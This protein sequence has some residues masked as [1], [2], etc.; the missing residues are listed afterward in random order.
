MKPPAQNPGTTHHARAR[1]HGAPRKIFHARLSIPVTPGALTLYY[2]KWIP[3]E[4]GPTGPIQDL[5][6]LT[7]T[8]NGQTLK[9]R[10]DLVDGWAF[11]LEVP[12]GATTFDVALDFIS[13]AG[14]R[15]GMFSGAATATDK[16]T[17]VSWNT[18]LL[19]PAGWTTDELTYQASLRLP[20]GW[21]FG[22]PLP[23][24]SQSG[25]EIRFQPGLSPCL[26]IRP[27]FPGEFFLVVPLS[28]QPTAGDR[29]R[30]RQRGGARR[31]ARGP[32]SL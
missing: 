27:L 3:G 13:P 10:R 11:H 26:S 28:G 6:G 17:V 24:A 15:E 21:K 32:R 2:P 23:V 7:F 22:T 29:H 30:G 8:A 14:G 25:A 16:M 20:A 19:Y 18:V 4:H 31:S 1:R 12:A 5:A 9:W